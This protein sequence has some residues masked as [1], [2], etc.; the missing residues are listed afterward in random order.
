MECDYHTNYKILQIFNIH[1][2]LSIVHF[3]CRSLFGNF[4][5]IRAYLNELRFEFVVIT[6]G[7][8]WINTKQKLDIVQLPGNKK[9][10]KDRQER[11]VV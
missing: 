1:Q 6:L 7:E 10:H 3:N 2:G 11:K 4:A 8:T 9:C 5:E